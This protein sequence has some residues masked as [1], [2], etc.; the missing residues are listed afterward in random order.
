LFS[1]GTPI[2]EG[3]QV[4]DSEL[5]ASDSKEGQ[6]CYDCRECMYNLCP[7]DSG[8][9]CKK[10]FKGTEVATSDQWLAC[11]ESNGVVSNSLPGDA[12]K[13]HGFDNWCHCA[14]TCDRRC[15][16]R[17]NRLDECGAAN[18]KDK[19]CGT[20]RA[21]LKDRCGH[22]E[23][24]P[25]T[26]CMDLLNGNHGNM[27]A[28]QWLACLES[29]GQN[30]DLDKTNV[31]RNPNE[32]NYNLRNS[33][34]AP[35][36]RQCDTE[37]HK[38]KDPDERAEECGANNV[39][40]SD[41]TVCR[42]CLKDQCIWGEEDTNETN[43]WLVLNGQVK[44]NTDTWLACL[45]S[46]GKSTSLADQEANRDRLSWDFGRRD[47]WAECARNC[48]TQCVKKPIINPRWVECSAKI[49]DRRRCTDC[50]DCLKHSCDFG[51]EG[52]F[53]NDVL[54][55]RRHTGDT[56]WLACL[57]S[58]GTT[59][60]IKLLDRDDELTTRDQ[61]DVD[62]GKHDSWAGCARTCDE[63][64]LKEDLIDPG[65]GQC[66]ANEI[67]GAFC[68][69]CRTCVKEKCTWSGFCADILT[70]QRKRGT[71]NWLACLE[72]NGSSSVLQDRPDGRDQ[73]S[74]DYGRRGTWSECARECDSR[75]EQQAPYTGPPLTP[76]CTA[77][78]LANET[79][80][81]G[82][83]ETCRACLHKECFYFREKCE[84]MISGV[85]KGTA[86]EWTQCLVYCGGG[87]PRDVRLRARQLEA[88]GAERTFLADD[89]LGTPRSLWCE[90]ARSCDDSCHHPE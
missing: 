75:C 52:S 44:S 12:E 5:L 64:C 79:G 6:D 77:G 37:C 65:I 40:T 10:V 19:N 70:N 81:G 90:C 57:E 20:C 26:Y 84:D 54:N 80:E 63:S 49:M 14:V 88:D 67:S 16:R 66:G 15:L 22:W 34:W 11:L 71:R 38:T 51:A 53:C 1:D 7:W 82:A 78:D 62:Y 29:D 61:L 59:Q 69:D 35:C 36:T 41:C 32:E 9:F 46:D 43:C 68:D 45:E 18:M 4:C 60:N 55:G 30:K 27:N 8:S 85:V 47:T 83:C 74:V 76:I 3:Y 23:E 72:S 73:L 31:E 17:E 25:D 21:C 56:Q 48:D 39:M 2:P 86:A 28:D 24:N 58:N 42:D 33:L 89:G 87:V 13:E 50:R